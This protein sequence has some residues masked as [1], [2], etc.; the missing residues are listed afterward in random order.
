VAFIEKGK[1]IGFTLSA[2][3]EGYQR[4]LE[5]GEFCPEF[6]KQLVEKKAGFETSIVEAKSAI[7]IIDK[8]L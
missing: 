3:K 7:K 8:M 5:Y 1:A 4:Y 2:I 6:T